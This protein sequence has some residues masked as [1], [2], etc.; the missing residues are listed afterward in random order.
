ME[1]NSAL[2]RMVEKGYAKVCGKAVQVAVVS[3]DMF[4]IQY[5]EYVL[6]N[7]V[8]LNYDSKGKPYLGNFELA[9]LN[10]T[11]E[12]SEYEVR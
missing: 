2:D 12:T 8:R 1:E 5:V 3:H 9:P 7:P 6:V 4:G 10:K 11:T